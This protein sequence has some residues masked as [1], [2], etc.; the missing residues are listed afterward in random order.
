MKRIIWKLKS[1]FFPSA[2]IPRPLYAPVDPSLDRPLLVVVGSNFNQDISNAVSCIPLGFA[3]GWAEVCGPAKVIPVDRLL[4]ELERYDNPAVYF[5][6]NLFASLSRDD[7]RRLRGSGMFCMVHVH[8]RA[9]DDFERRHPLIPRDESRSYLESYEKLL[10]AE[11]ALVWNSVG[12]AGMEWYRGWIEDGLRWE[13]IYP[14]ADPSR[15]FPDP[16]TDRFGHVTM[17]YVGGYWPEKAQSFDLYLRPWEEILT[18]YGYS[19]WPYKGYAGYLNEED[20]R[21]LYSTAGL[22]PLVTT[23]AGWAIAEITERYLKAP[24]CRAFCIADQNPAVREIF[25]ADEVLQAESAENFHDLVREFLAG[26]ID[27]ERWRLSAHRAVMERHLYRN[28]ALQVQAALSG[29]TPEWSAA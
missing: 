3:K 29:T 27:C 15:Y 7:A 24:A 28:R 5:S 13:T 20:E 22:V 12:A 19:R 26:R 8:P 11:P 10:L 18:V 6:Q 16:D 25:S 1:R 17:A 9:F 14:A 21:R 2:H 4:H 23:P